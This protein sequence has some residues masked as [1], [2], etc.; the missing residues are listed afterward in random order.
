MN[1]PEPYGDLVE[2]FREHDH[3]T[4]RVGALKYWLLGWT[5]AIVEGRDLGEFQMEWIE[6]DE[7]SDGEEP[8]SGAFGG[9]AVHLIVFGAVGLLSPFG[10]AVVRHFGSE[11]PPNMVCG[12]GCEPLSDVAGG[13]LLSMVVVMAVLWIVV[14]AVGGFSEQTCE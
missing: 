7:P 8:G 11:R 6:D 13:V 3:S 14:Q 4:P 1:G 12:I 10:I 2:K 9:F 5:L